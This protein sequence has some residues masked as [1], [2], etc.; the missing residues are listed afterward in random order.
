AIV[1]A[2]IPAPAD[3]RFDNGVHRRRPSDLV[4][5]KRPPRA[6]FLGEHTPRNRLRCRNGDELANAVRIKLA[7]AGLLH[8]PFL[9]FAASRSAAT[10]NAASAS[11]QSPSSQSR[12]VSMPRVSTA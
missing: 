4:V 8:Q 1:A 2:L 10:L 6:D 12:N 9:I 7:G 5:G 3:M 11:S